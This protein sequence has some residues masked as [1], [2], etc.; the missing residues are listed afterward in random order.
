MYHYNIQ[1]IVENVLLSNICVC[2][3]AHERVLSFEQMS[4]TFCM[5]VFN[6]EHTQKM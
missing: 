4:Q 2:V 3:C 6:L 1:Y 5:F